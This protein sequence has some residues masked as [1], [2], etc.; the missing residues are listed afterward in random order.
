MDSGKLK[1]GIDLDIARYKDGVRTTPSSNPPLNATQASRKSIFPMFREQGHS[2]RLL[3]PQRH[4]QKVWRLL[5]CME[6]YFQFG[7]GCNIYYTPA[8]A[9]GFAPHYDDIDAFILQLEGQKRWRMYNPI[10]TL[11]LTSSADFTQDQIGD[12]IFEVTLAPG[13]IMYF[14]RGWIHQAVSVADADS[15][16]MTVSVGQRTTWYD[17]M[18]IAVP[19][20]LE[21]A[22]E[23]NEEIRECLPVGYTRYMGLIHA[24]PEDEGESDGPA[25]AAPPSPNLREAF[26]NKAVTIFSEMVYSMNFDRSADEFAAKFLH[27]RLPPVLSRQ[28]QH[29]SKSGY[30]GSKLRA[31]PVSRKSHVRVIRPDVLRMTVEGDTVQLWHSVANSRLYHEEPPHGI[32]FDAD[33]GPA[34]EYLFSQYPAYVQ[35]GGD[36]GVWGKAGLQLSNAEKSEE[37]LLICQELYENGLLVTRR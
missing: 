7:A 16:H 4:N 30:G 21:Q 19:Q 36:W 37:Q 18:R 26:I 22:L 17:Y 8:G 6:D 31:C 12:P 11:P 10:T 24:N 14:P 32:E 29:R 5:A 1:L 20:A 33:A 35:V 3:S 25:T 23:D 28:E 34:L 27:D 13:D 15:L 2:I 9:Q